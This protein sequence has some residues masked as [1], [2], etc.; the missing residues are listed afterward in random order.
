MRLGAL[1]ALGVL[2]A[3]QLVKAF[4]LRGGVGLPT[5]LAPFLTLTLRWNRGVSFSLLTQDSARG[6]AVLLA[7][8][9]AATAALAV[10]LWRCRTWP[11]AAGLG[12]IIGGALG[13]AIDRWSHGAVIDF[14]DLHLLGRHLFVFN[15]A[16]A[17]I[18]VGVALL[19]LDFA[20]GSRAS[21]P[22]AGPETGR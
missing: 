1:V 6:Q 15:V 19:I 8:T 12:A 14:L 13:N 21:Q 2:F 16:D 3:D 5:P 7:F 4:V 18:N 22:E 11:A 9:L 17:A 20:F 10:W